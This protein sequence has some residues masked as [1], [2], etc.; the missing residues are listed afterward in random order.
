MKEDNTV[1]VKERFALL[2]VL[3]ASLNQE[4]EVILK[5]QIKGTMEPTLVEISRHL[6]YVIKAERIREAQEY[7]YE[8]YYNSRA[9][10]LID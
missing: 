7:I 3:Y 1:E 5:S 9:G 8:F 4:A 10:Y 2:G 6:G